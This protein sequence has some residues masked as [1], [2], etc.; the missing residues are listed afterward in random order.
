MNILVTIDANYLP[1]LQVMLTSLFTNQIKDGE[2]FT[3]YLLHADL[4]PEEV[5]TLRTYIEGFGHAFVEVLI[6]SDDFKDAPVNKH[7]SRAMYYRLLAFDLLPREVERILYLDPDLLIINPLDAL[8]QLD[9]GEK[10]FAA[11]HHDIIG[12]N[13]LNKLRFKPVEIENYY[14]TGV[15]LMNLSVLRQKTS[16]AEIFQYVKDH[17]ILALPDQD[18]FNGLY[19][20]E[21]VSVDEHRYNYDVRQYYYYKIKS[22]GEWDMKR[23]ITETSILHFCGKDKPWHEDYSGHFHSLYMHYWHLTHQR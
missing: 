22:L 6:S 3:I 16:A 19:A 2:P 8:Y 11:A 18:V 12:V 13:E 4:K 7:Y 1:P 14:N 21:I 5:D 17:K 10:C 15:L 9:L 20:K 23:V